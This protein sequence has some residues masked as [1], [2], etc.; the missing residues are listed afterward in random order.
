VLQDLAVA[1]GTVKER[2]L[3]DGK[4][5]DMEGVYMDLL[6]KSNGR[7]VVERSAGRMLGPQ[8]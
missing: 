6:K 3:R 5:V 1:H 7:W 4:Q 8:T 2:R